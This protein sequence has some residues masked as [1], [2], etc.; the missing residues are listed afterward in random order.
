MNNIKRWFFVVVGVSL[1]ALLVFGLLAVAP[2][3]AQGPGGMMGGP[4]GGMMGRGMM[5]Q[6]YGP[7]WMMGYTQGFT[8]TEGYAGP[9]PFG[10]DMMGGMM[11]RGMMGGGMMW[12]DNNP[13]FCH[14]ASERCRN[15]RSD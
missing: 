7:G 2:A 3:L 14:R 9:C 11:G 1:V 15:H 12:S 13:F 4:G 8:G 6:G 5:G 10:G